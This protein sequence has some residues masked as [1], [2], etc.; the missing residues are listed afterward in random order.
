VIRANGRN[1][2][3]REYS[4]YDLRCDR[5]GLPRPSRSVGL[6]STGIRKYGY[7]F[8]TIAAKTEEGW[9][10]YRYLDLSLHTYNHGQSLYASAYP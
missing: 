1:K 9:I 5:Y 7:K 4:R 10:L 2:Q 3:D 8:R 6:R